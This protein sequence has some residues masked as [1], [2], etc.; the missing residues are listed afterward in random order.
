VTINGK[1]MIW[2]V[3][4]VVLF[5]V[6]LSL[7]R[8]TVAL[9]RNH[10]RYVPTAWK[11]NVKRIENVLLKLNKDALLYPCI[12]QNDA[13]GGGRS[14]LSAC[15]ISETNVRISIKF[16]FVGLRCKCSGELHSV[17]IGIMQPLS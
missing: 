15:F 3:R 12:M 8:S 1:V 14:I 16:G 4:C 6:P 10:W 7:I 9:S 5:N 13:Q 2:S 17:H 11:L